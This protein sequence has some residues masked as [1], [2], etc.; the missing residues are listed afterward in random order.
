MKALSSKCL[1]PVV[2]SV[3]SLN[4]LILIFAQMMYT[5]DHLGLVMRK[6]GFTPSFNR[7]Q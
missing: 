5:N 7:S 1:T 4:Q 3:Q 6:A 2:S